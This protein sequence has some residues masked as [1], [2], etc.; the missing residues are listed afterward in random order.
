MLTYWNQDLQNFSP[1]RKELQNFIK[2]KNRFFIITEKPGKSSICKG[3][4]SGLV[5]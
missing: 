5:D 3:Q 4:G 2:K 1:N